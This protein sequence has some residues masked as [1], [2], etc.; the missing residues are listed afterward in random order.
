[1]TRRDQLALTFFATWTIIGLYLDG[2]AHEHQK[3]ETFF[4]P[5]HGVLYSG[6]T[7]GVI[8]FAIDG[9]RRRRAGEATMDAPGG[10]LSSVGLALFIAGAV[11]DFIWHAVFGIEVNLEA[12]L[13]PTHLMLMT[14]G[15][16]LV[17]GVLRDAWMA[18]DGW[19]DPNAPTF[20]E[21]LPVMMSLLLT[22][23]VVAFFT[24]YLSAFNNYTVADRPEWFRQLRDVQEQR[25]ILGIAGILFTNALVML[26]MLLALRRWKPPLGTFTVFVTMLAVG[27][28]GLRGFEKWAFILPAALG[29]VVADLLVH[30]LRPSI[31]RVRQARIVAGAVPLAMWT[32]YFSV[33]SVTWGVGWSAEL[34]VGSTFLAV[35]SGLA[36]SLLA[37]PM[38]MG[39]ATPT[40]RVPTPPVRTPE[41]D[42][43]LLAS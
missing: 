24:M 5:W 18:A 21:F 17:S 33:Y 42:R 23:A 26:P 12:L 6:F 15:V 34:V 7:V 4:T 3:P 20:A 31:D 40:T 11:G 43:E 14:G 39:A 36:L 38:S 35:L 2:W 19:R 1:M 28:Q 10:R 32:F 22:T 13:S 9:W 29:G 8:W 41:R 16:I 25:Q 27:I 37:F 30:L